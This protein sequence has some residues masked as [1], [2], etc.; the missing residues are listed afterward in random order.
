M[1]TWRGEH[2]CA[3]REKRVW[4]SEKSWGWTY[5]RNRG[6]MGTTW[7]PRN[8]I[9]LDQAVRGLSRHHS[10]LTPNQLGILLKV[11]WKQ[12]VLTR[13]TWEATAT[14][15][16]TKV[17]T[18]TTNQ[19]NQQQYVTK[20]NVNIRF[21]RSRHVLPII[22]NPNGSNNVLFVWISFCRGSAATPEEAKHCKYCI[23]GCQKC[24][25]HR[26]LTHQCEK[27]QGDSA[28]GKRVT[29]QVWR[30]I[31]LTG[32]ISSRG[33]AC[34]TFLMNKRLLDSFFYD[35]F[36]KKMFDRFLWLF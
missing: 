10:A 4:F 7:S 12:E 13:A 19:W 31:S 23:S 11:N 2:N 21:R 28:G 26:V 20:N 36:D 18:A 16:A 3:T 33:R 9:G 5:H 15:T 30:V 27:T 1:W 35:L 14:Q 6:S 29:A 34:M 25:P 24:N 22:T 17:L 32:R 8:S